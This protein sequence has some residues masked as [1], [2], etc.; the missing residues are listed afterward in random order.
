VFGLFEAAVVG[1]DGAPT[2]G[3][4][5]GERVVGARLLLDCE[6]TNDV[7]SSTA[8]NA[9][10]TARLP[11]RTVTQGARARERPRTRIG[12]VLCEQP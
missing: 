7:H 8:I 4:R 11:V 9:V 12:E 10:V 6:L 5:V 2:V 3:G 1:A